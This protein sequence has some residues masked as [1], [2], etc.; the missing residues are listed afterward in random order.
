MSKLAIITGAD[1]GMGTEITRAVAQA[2]YHVIMLCYTLF[3]G[4]ERKNQLIL[5]TGNKEI[6][7]RQV[8]LSSMASVTNIADDLLGRGKHIDLLMN[9]AGTMSSGGLITTEDGLEYT[10]AVNYVAPFFTDFEIIASDGSR[11]PDCEHGFLHVF[12]R[13]DYS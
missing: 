3:K 7:V 5:E 11:N 6:E 4:E 8:D 12:H 1:G 10:V 2:G 9:N 13:E